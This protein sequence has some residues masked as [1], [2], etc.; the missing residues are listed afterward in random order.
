MNK[1][2]IVGIIVV[3]VILGLILIF[4]SNQNVRQEEQT[5]S[6][7]QAPI[8][9]NAETQ[10]SAV[11]EATGNVDDATAAILS[12]IESDEL[13]SVESDQSLLSENDS[14]V[15]DIGQSLSGATQ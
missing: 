10:Q 3:I 11:V 1:K 15:G 7:S 5:P 4:A 14:A 6:P 8:T 13:P 12:D 9:Q 2:Y